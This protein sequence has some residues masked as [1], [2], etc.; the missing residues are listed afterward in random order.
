[1]SNLSEL[2]NKMYQALNCDIK[3]INLKGFGGSDSIYTK[4]VFLYNMIINTNFGNLIVD[5]MRL[6]ELFVKTKDHV[7]FK[8]I[9][10]NKYC[11]ADYRKFSDSYTEFSLFPADKVLC[12]KYYGY[13]KAGDESSKDVFEVLEIDISNC[14]TMNNFLHFLYT[15][16]KKMNNIPSARL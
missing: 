5:S 11:R 1:M 16:F 8:F 12:I 4:D 14:P 2:I 3:E 10:M 6:V 13:F 7:I 15:K 9:N